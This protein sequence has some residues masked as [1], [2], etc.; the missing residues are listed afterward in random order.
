VARDEIADVNDAC[1]VRCDREGFL[2]YPGVTDHNILLVE[3]LA[4]PVHHEVRARLAEAGLLGRRQIRHNAEVVRRPD[5][6]NGEIECKGA[7]GNVQ[8]RPMLAA[9]HEDV[10]DPA[11]AL[12]WHL[13]GDD[14]R[15]PRREGMPR[16]SRPRRLPRVRVADTRPLRLWRP[17]QK[18]MLPESGMASKSRVASS[19]SPTRLTPTVILCFVS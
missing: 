13:A 6:G 4:A 9:S 16:L 8:R 19:L 12:E 5:A 2:S 15:V 17:V 10:V 18:R 14:E 7:A 1:L 11:A 3:T